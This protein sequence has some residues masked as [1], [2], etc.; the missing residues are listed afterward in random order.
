VEVPLKPRVKDNRPAGPC[1]RSTVFMLSVSLDP[2]RAVV[3]GP[4]TCCTFA[5]SPSCC[6][7]GSEN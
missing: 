7:H 6:H 4:S 1:V 5:A 3:M 2:V